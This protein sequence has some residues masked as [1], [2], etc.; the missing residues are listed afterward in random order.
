MTEDLAPRYKQGDS[1]A[2][3]HI[4]GEIYPL[5]SYIYTPAQR[6]TK[7]PTAIT[8]TTY[9]NCYWGELITNA[10]T[11]PRHHAYIATKLHPARAIVIQSED[12]KT[13]ADLDRVP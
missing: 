2:T 6:V 3:L 4:Q 5:A 13:L 1:T 11:Q 10:S 7:G 12:T 8:T 9:L